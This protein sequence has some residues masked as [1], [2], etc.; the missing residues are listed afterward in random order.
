MTDLL[1]VVPHP[2]DEVFGCGGVIA[3]MR[4][5]G[6]TV[7]T[8]TLTR[9]RAGRSLDLCTRDQLPAMREAELRGS[10]AALGVEDA[11]IL[12]HPDFVPDADR[13]LEPH[14]GLRAVPESVLMA[15]IVAV[16]ER[17]RP[18][19]LLTFPP[20]G[21]NG[22][23][24][25]VITHR[26]ALAAA[27]VVA[28]PPERVFVFASD[29]PFDQQAREG[30]LPP[31]EVRDLQLPAT[32]HVDVGPFIEAKLRAMGNHQTQA[33]S[34]LGFMRS[35]PRRLLVESFHRMTPQ[36]PAGYGSQTVLWI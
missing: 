34:V 21:S 12:D 32:H 3:R 16:L 15:D 5:H 23:P 27:E 25:H 28:T 26:L 24:D 19:T 30:F 11:T 7:A 4:A 18:R 8:L 36:V 22:H 20:N 1:L 33:L 2:D 10:L 9:G 14:P 35:M 17:C 6:R 13:G 29:M 31:S